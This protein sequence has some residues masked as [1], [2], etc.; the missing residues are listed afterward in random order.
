VQGRSRQFECCPD[1]SVDLAGGL[2]GQGNIAKPKGTK[3]ASS[4]VAAWQ[5][6]QVV[7]PSIFQARTGQGNRE[8][9]RGA[10]TAS[11]NPARIPQCRQSE[12]T[13]RPFRRQVFTDRPP[14][15]W[16]QR[17]I[18]ITMPEGD[19]KG[20]STPGFRKAA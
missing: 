19:E 9:G 7:E 13:V 2:L 15:E 14:I 4:R 8:R 16:L 17:L 11:T 10:V 1:D 3:Q 6:G 12:E 20:R 18:T 5:P